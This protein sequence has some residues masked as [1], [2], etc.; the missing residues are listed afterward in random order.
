MNGIEKITGRIAQ[1]AQAEAQNLLAQA[2]AEAEAIRARRTEEARAEAAAILAEA[3]AQAAI[4]EER[5]ASAAELEGRKL[6]L[7]E[8]QAVLDEAFRL[9]L[10]QL[11]SMEREE[12]VAL[13]AR[14]L[15]QVS[16]T[17]QEE[18]IMNPADRTQV[19]KEIVTR[20]NAILA[21]AVAPRLP[22]A[23]LNSPAGEVVSRVVGG[24]SAVA[25]GTGMLTLAAETRNI[26]GG[27][28]LAD[29]P[30]ET[31]CALDTLLNEQRPSL[32]PEIAALLF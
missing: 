15:A 8:K 31:N 32:T 14:L 19:G 17:G 10:E 26:P 24:V 18:V 6:V 2:Q 3:E 20:A 7:A 23:I 29:G 13:M 5:I 25:H 4:R 27:F 9:A 22:Q 30:V 28:I 1:D 12:Y 21:Q 11:C 16:A